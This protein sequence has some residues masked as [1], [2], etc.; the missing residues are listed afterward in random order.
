M[1]LS[2][3]V[4]GGGQVAPRVRKAGIEILFCAACGSGFW[5]PDA[6]FDPAAL[7]GDG[8]FADPGQPA[9]YDDYGALE[10]A[11]RA[12]FA[13]RLRGVGPPPG[14]GSRLLDLGAAYGFAVDEARRAGWRATGLE[15]SRVAALR[16]APVAG[17]AG[18]AVGD[19]QRTP[20]GDA[21]FAAV[22]MWDVLEHLS[23]PHAAIAEVARLLHP[24]GR[25]ALSTGDAGSLA[26][27][28]SGAHWHLY[29]LPEHLFFFSREGLRRLLA[30]H[31]LGIERM[32]A[33]GARYPLGYLVE[34]LR[35][36]LLGR[37]APAPPRFP[38]ARVAIPVNLFDVVTVY[39]VRGGT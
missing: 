7:Y 1:A 22:T 38:G 17:P 24:G 16:A 19:A 2:C 27:R 18:V 29:N 30:A 37:T 11:L 9:G 39:A 31:G 6:G 36:T 8:Y 23:D 3:P 14:P 35:K 5:E 15:R 34:R 21:C 4:C 10:P 33:E 12:N 28:L 32:R 25:L 13:R 26:A 20:F